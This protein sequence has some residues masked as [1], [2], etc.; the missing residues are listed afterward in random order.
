LQTPVEVIHMPKGTSSWK[1]FPGHRGVL[2]FLASWLLVLIFIAVPSG[3]W[4]Q[5]ANKEG[6]DKQNIQKMLILLSE[7]VVRLQKQMQDLQK[8]PS[9]P[10]TN[11][12]KEELSAQIDGLNRNFESLATQLNADDLLTGEQKK[13]D[14]SQKL[15][16]LVLPLLEAMNEL[17]AKPRKIE[18]LK[19]QIEIFQA[20]LQKYEEASKNIE[21]LLQT[22]H[23]NVDLDDPKSKSFL[24]RL[25]SLKSKYNPELVRLRLEESKRAL[26]GELKNTEPFIDTATKTIKSFFK[27]RGLNLL[28]T[29]VIF[30]A[31]WYIL[32]KMR[33][34]VVGEKSFLKFEPWIQKVLLT[35][36]SILVLIICIVSSLISLYLLNDW[37]LLSIIIL[38][39]VAVAWASRQ[40]IPRLFEEVRLALNLGT[41]KE[42]ER[43]IWN[44]VPW[45]VQNIGLQ[46]VLVNE[47]LEGGN[48]HLPVRMLIEK[49]SRPLAE[50]EPWF[51]TRVGDWVMLNDGT[52]G[53][54]KNQTMEQVILELKGQ[55]E[56]YYSTPD[57]LGQSPRNISQGFRYDMLFGLDYEVQPRICD[58][59]PNLF[60]EGL[61]KY[62]KHHFQEGSPDFNHLEIT[63]DNAGSSSLNLKIVVH[64]EGRCADQHE[65]I[66]REIQTTLVRIC[67]DHG[68]RIPFTQLTVNLA[69]DIKHWAGSSPDTN[70]KSPPSV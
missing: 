58:E 47:R 16:A 50:N 1:R 61:K 55:T 67:N 19:N 63:F 13:T 40:F 45:Y 32:I 68:L 48:I 11:K 8:R 27:H 22:A 44:G 4:A 54:V 28:I 64:V 7:Q 30:V 9:T 38:F 36:Y 66:W 21:A 23:R 3:L 46:A 69:D 17:T 53:R 2:F 26:A 70:P 41:V 42:N 34:Y 20:K 18:R 60:M 6:P 5:E 10:S 43:L 51:P 59:I 52:Y 62:L 24:N 35:A 56:K 31:L 49:N 65:E 39:L 25:E 15:E 29:L 37:L 14:W 57:F 12:K 33:I